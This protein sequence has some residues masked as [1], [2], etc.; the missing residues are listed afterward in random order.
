MNVLPRLALGLSLAVA[1]FPFSSLRA[2][3][4]ASA[5]P[6][7]KQMRDLKITVRDAATQAPVPG[8]TVTLFEGMAPTK[9]TTDAAGVVVLPVQIDVPMA[10]KMTQFSF[11]VTDPGHEP[12][13][14]EWFADAGH[15]RDGLP[16]EYTVNL[17]AGITIGGVVRD[18]HGA[19]VAGAKILG[20]AAG[21]RPRTLGRGTKMQQEYGSISI[22]EE[23]A[24]FTDAQGVWRKEHFPSEV[25][26]IALDVIRLGA[27]RTHFMMGDYRGPADRSG[28]IDFSMLRNQ[29]AVF[30]LKD[31]VTLRGVIVDESGQPIAG[32][33]LR[34]RDAGTRNQPDQFT[35]NADGTFVLPHWEA[36][37]VLLTAEKN[38]FQ[39]KSVTIATA[40]DVASTKL[41][42]SRAKPLVLRVLGDNDEPLE[43]ELQS[44][45][46]P[47]PEQIV[48][49]RGKTDATGRVEWPTAPDRP[50]TIWI[51]PKSS[52]NYP[53]R[54]DRLTA[55]GKEHII[56]LRSGADKSIRVH[57][58]VVDAES[59][60]P[61]PGFEVWRRVANSSFK[62]WGEPAEN[63]EFTKEIMAEELPN[64]FVPSYRL[65]VRA[66][67]YTG[68]G[69]ETLDFS[70]GDQDLTLKLT[71]GASTLATDPPPRRRA[72]EGLSG[73]SNPPLLALAASVANLI[74]TGDAA[75]FV[76]A[77]NASQAD[78]A[79]VIPKGTDPN[80]G[81]LGQDPDRT[82]QRHEKAIAA[83][84]A[85][86]LEQARRLGLAPGKIRFLVKSVS[87]PSNGSSVYRL[88]GQEVSV[89][90]AMAIRI[91]LTGEP[92]GD[93]G[94]RPLRGDFELSVGGAHQLPAGWR[95]EEGVRWAAFPPG[96]ADAAM[97]RELQLANRAAS[98]NFSDQRTLSGPDDEALVK[99]A[100]ALTELVRSRAVPAFV[101]STTLSRDETV[102]FFQRAGW[103][104]AAAADEAWQRVSTGLTAT[105]A[106]LVGSLDRAGIDLSD[107]QIKVRQ[108]LGERPSFSRFGLLDGLRCGP[109][110]VTLAVESPR[111]SKAGR[112]IAGNYTLAVGD[113][114]RVNDRWVLIEDK[115]RWQEFPKGLLSADELKNLEFENHIAEHG[116]L[117]N[118]TMAPEIDLVR[119]ADATH[120][121]LS[122]FRGKVVVLEFWATWC[123][124][125]QEP[126][127][128]LQHLREDHPDWKD[129]VEIVTLSID[130]NAAA[131]TDHLAKKQWTKTANHWAGEGAWESGPARAFRVRGVP[132]AY[133][134][135]RNG[136]VVEAGHPMS[137]DFGTIVN[138]QLR[139]SSPWVSE[140]NR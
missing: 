47:S 61:V 59:G 36:D 92:V 87:S 28:A 64:G 74:E 128:H 72:G 32:V 51:A 9:L 49:W 57:F 71:K 52:K 30:V 105:A 19:P 53:I 120:V 21:L 113:A 95:S 107:A 137:M 2:Q 75:A 118:G 22:T 4:P 45:P 129:R 138:T 114:V 35:N 24:I 132:T 98:S 125:C 124:P 109:L 80:E 16:T 27:P 121:P 41:V 88:G 17:P 78:W 117:P 139:E 42:L 10:E 3:T 1:C 135:D 70:N 63:G 25:T 20:Y 91:V 39:T 26:M 126:M 37:N 122:R 84:A 77:T 102:A 23:D 34:A 67:G 15:V 101:A 69:S 44:D 111:L 33:Q 93:T 133:V 83:T 96:L 97:Q 79:G 130:D 123:G 106:A 56:R 40:G 68:W 46:N 94:G 58:R 76:Q 89:P 43:A 29:R 7:K 136:K 50:V 13:R 31:G 62:P 12:R 5:E 73:E 140:P 134:I 108:V 8:A 90:Y 119:L 131:A 86:V 115:V 127:E 116:T 85:H 112:P 18:E 100:S 110:R 54:S 66:T 11:Q 65:Q 99:F 104:G 81:P 38:G 6:A 82:I 48:T 60:E 103:G 55:D 14:V